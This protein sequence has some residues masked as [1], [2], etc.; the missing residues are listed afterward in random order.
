MPSSDLLSQC[1]SVSGVNMANE[2][3]TQ[4]LLTKEPD[5]N[6]TSSAD[7]EATAEKQFL[8][9]QK[10]PGCRYCSMVGCK[11]WAWSVSCVCCTQADEMAQ[12]EFQKKYGF[13]KKPHTQRKISQVSHC[14]EGWTER[15]RHGLPCAHR[16]ES[17]TLTPET[18]TWKPPRLTERRL[19]L[20]QEP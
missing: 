15:H 11:Q 4:V 19:L 3:S 1:C 16:V 5:Q 13:A 7:E 9:P 6:R 18:T 10:V 8:S 2:G 14:F 17:N 20:T 12:G